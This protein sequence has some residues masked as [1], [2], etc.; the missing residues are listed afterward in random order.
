MW[1][2]VTEM[3]TTGLEVPL[4]DGILGAGD[5]GLF[6]ALVSN[7][8]LHPEVLEGKLRLHGARGVQAGNVVA[9]FSG[10]IQPGCTPRMASHIAAVR[11]MSSRGCP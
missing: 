1:A 9:T 11:V 5:L 6:H 8:V 4:P 7:R 3:R 2:D 10:A